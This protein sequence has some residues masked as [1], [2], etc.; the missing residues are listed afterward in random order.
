MPS[1]FLEIGKCYWLLP[2]LLISFLNL[3]TADGHGSFERG[4]DDDG[5]SARHTQWSWGPLISIHM[6]VLCWT[7]NRVP[8]FEACRVGV[9]SEVWGWRRWSEDEWGWFTPKMKNLL[10]YPY[11]SGPGPFW[12][13]G[14]VGKV[15]ASNWSSVIPSLFF[16]FNGPL[17]IGFSPGYRQHPMS[18]LCRRIRARVLKVAL[19]WEPLV[20]SHISCVQLFATPWTLAFQAP[21]PMRFSRKEYWSGLPFHFPGDLPGSG[22]EPA[23][24]EM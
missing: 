9:R 17:L 22:I 7:H 20:L 4:K 5:A 10:L 14:G 3:P 24:P 1:T 23:S 6:S 11:P 12:S 15:C 21:L 16:F 18:S 8:I 2:E 13:F 19:H